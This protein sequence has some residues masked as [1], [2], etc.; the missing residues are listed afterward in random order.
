M[1][2]FFYFRGNP[3]TSV[4]TETNVECGLGTK[5]LPVV[6][7]VPGGLEYLWTLLP[8]ASSFSPACSSCWE[9]IPLTP[10][11]PDYQCPMH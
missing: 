1:L 11:S 5:C 10:V 8:A 7:G 4:M 9:E 6:D 3:K 2:P